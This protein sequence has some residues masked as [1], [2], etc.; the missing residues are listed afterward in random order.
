MA[1]DTRDTAQ[2]RAGPSTTVYATRR[3]GNTFTVVVER[4]GVR[5]TMLIRA[6]SAL[7]ALVKAEE[8][9]RR[10][11]ALDGTSPRIRRPQATGRFYILPEFRDRLPHIMPLRVYEGLQPFYGVIGT[12]MVEIVLPIHAQGLNVV[13]DENGRMKM[14]ARNPWL[15]GGFGFVGT[16]VIMKG[17]FK[18]LNDADIA[19]V[20]ENLIASDGGS[21]ALHGR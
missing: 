11:G 18:P 4:F 3:A 9:L 20:R 15:R 21:T 8:H 12:D 1:Y 19:W 16:L 17:D 2:R 13:G 5:S 14:R 7:D 10:S 6:G